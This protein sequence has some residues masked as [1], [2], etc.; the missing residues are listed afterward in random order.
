VRTYRL[1]EVGVDGVTTP[2]Y[3]DVTVDVRKGSSYVTV[4]KKLAGA[5]NLNS[6]QTGRL[7]ERVQT[8]A[9]ALLG[10]GSLI[11]VARILE[12]E[13]QIPLNTAIR[14]YQSIDLAEEELLRVARVTSGV[15]PFIF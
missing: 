3:E 11:S 4:A 15:S 9:V 10:G 8:G 7:I 13:F 5:M 2:V 14:A 1:V 12:V 6:F